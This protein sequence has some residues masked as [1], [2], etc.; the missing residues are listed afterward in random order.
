VLRNLSWGNL[1][2]E[3]EKWVKVLFKEERPVHPQQKADKEVA[4]LRKGNS[5][6]LLPTRGNLSL[7]LL[8]AEKR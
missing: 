5:V 7:Y 4:R 6:S 8:H 3:G 1:R 2:C